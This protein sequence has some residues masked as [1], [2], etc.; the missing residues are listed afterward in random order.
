MRKLLLGGAFAAVLS[1]SSG[2]HATAIS[3][4]LQQIGVNGGAISTVTTDGGT[5]AA[6]FGGTYGSFT[7]NSVSTQ[8]APLL[9]QGALSTT[10]IQTSSTAAGTISIYITESGLTSPTGAASWLSAFTSNTF[11]G[12]AISVVESTFFSNVNAIYDGTPIASTTFTSIG[13][14]ANTSTAAVGPLYSETVKYVV[15]VGSGFSN[16]NDTINLT[17]SAIPEPAS[18]A[19]LGAGLIG[20]GLIR[21]KRA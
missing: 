16:V 18:M 13:A 5:G 3:I 9:P 4:G 19:I 17:A 14:G 11:S 21:R 12:A 10:S 1:L 2:A 20:I 6:F 15:T 7:F 8:G